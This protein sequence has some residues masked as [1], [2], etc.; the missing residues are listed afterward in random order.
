CL[1]FSARL[2]LQNSDPPLA[3]VDHSGHWR[4]S[5]L[6][7]CLEEWQSRRNR[8]RSATTL[9]DLGIGLGLRNFFPNQPSQYRSSSL[10]ADLPRNFHRL[11]SV[12]VFLSGAIG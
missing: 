8:P 2:S 11:R 10:V 7:Q 9:P 4:I 12:H 6:A 3:G 5:S 1:V